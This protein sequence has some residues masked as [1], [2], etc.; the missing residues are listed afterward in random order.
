VSFVADQFGRNLAY[1]RR[2]AKI[3]QE[4]L[5]FRASLHRTAIGMLER[6][7]RIP[8]IDTLVKLAGALGVSADELLDGLEWSPGAMVSGSFHFDGEGEP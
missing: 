4:E 6:G 7:E 8:R 2:R 3:S 1:C 5:S